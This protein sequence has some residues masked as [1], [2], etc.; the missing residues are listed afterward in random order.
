MS[1]SNPDT[2]RWIKYFPYDTPREHQVLAINNII[3]AFENGT[4]YFILSAGT[5]V[6]KSAIAATVSQYLIH[7]SPVDAEKYKK[8]SLF[9]T[10]QKLL[11]AQYEK[12]FYKAGM[13]SIKSASNYQCSYK[14]G[15]NCSESQNELK[16]EDK[17]SRFFKACSFGCV[18]RKAKESFLNA[19]LSVTNFPY[20]LT[21]SNYS[22]KITARQLLVVDEAHN[23]DAELS[24]FIEITASE[25][26]ATRVLKLKWPKANTQ[27]QALKWIEDVYYPKLNSHIAHIDVMLLKYEGLKSKLEQFVS[28]SRQ[29]QSMKSHRKKLELFLDVYTK[30]N[31]VFE[32]QDSEKRGFKKFSFK[33]IDIAPFSDSYLLRLG[34]RVLFM[35][36]TII[37]AD[38]FTELVGIDPKLT[39]SLSLES[40]FP[41]ENKPI[42]FMPIGKMV[43]RDI[44]ATLPKLVEAIKHILEEHKGEKGVIHTHT[45]RIANYIK[46]NIRSRRL[47][48]PDASNRDQMLEKHINGSQPTVLISPSM[49][50]GVNLEGEASRFQVLCK[51]PYPY[52]GDKLVK[53]KMS[54]WR[55][56]LSFQTAKT[57]IQAVGRSIR[58]ETDTAVTYILDAD[59]DRFYDRNKQLFPKD[60]R[61]SLNS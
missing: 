60:F 17:S 54:K 45:Y 40:P 59:F 15:N 16:A 53:K 37:D 29:I 27:L 26:F 7:N 57:I 21:E 1:S 48:V 61:D 28:L 20:L 49:T 32:I 12:D 14:K 2:E 50:E 44:D 25:Q 33:P 41:I 56:W 38:N 36:A 42:L 43:S 18:Y 39:Q 51:V 22:G 19:Y 9:V 3:D 58:S 47:I 31:W 8:G 10:T 23:T 6:G 34:E 46:N 5:G 11:Q 13:R 4:K 24:K 35:S 30:D 52:M 55:W